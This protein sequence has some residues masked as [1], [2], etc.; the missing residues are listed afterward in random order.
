MS[1]KLIVA[2]DKNF[3]IGYKNHLLFKISKDLKRF[4]GLT[5]GHF[6]VMGRK[7]FE[8]LPNP[9][10]N[11]TN[12]ILT[13]NSNYTVDDPSVLVVTDIQKMI[14]H[15]LD[16]GKQDKDLWVIGGAEI[17]KEFLPY[18]D[19]VYLTYVDKEVEK[20]DTYFPFADM[21]KIGFELDGCQAYYEETL[22]CEVTFANYVNLSK[23]T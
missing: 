4:K 11:R 9:L 8:S 22:D 23:V 21:E 1:I 7:T 17:Y 3:G 12:V 2:V 15:Y 10:P 13:R 18:V 19:R 20:V 14:R 6:V 5:T 16:T